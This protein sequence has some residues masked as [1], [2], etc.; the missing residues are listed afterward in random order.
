MQ[1][2]WFLLCSDIIIYVCNGMLMY[3]TMGRSCV[4]ILQHIVYIFATPLVFNY[5]LP[6]PTVGHRL[7]LSDIRNWIVNRRVSKTCEVHKSLNAFCIHFCSLSHSVT[8][9]VHYGSKARRASRVKSIKPSFYH[10]S[11]FFFSR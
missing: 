4:E 8:P 11:W 6:K 7:D 3:N 5:N 2:Q 1:V 10:L 9:T